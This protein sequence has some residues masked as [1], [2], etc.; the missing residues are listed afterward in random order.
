MPKFKKNPNPIMKKQAYGKA[1]SPFTMKSGN[2]TTF[3]EMGSSPVLQQADATL[4]AAA[5]AAAMASVP[6]DLSAQYK[7]AANAAIT[8]DKAKTDFI[9]DSINVV[10]DTSEKV[11]KAVKKKKKKKEK[12]E[13][14]E[15]NKKNGNGKENGGN[16]D[17]GSGS[18]DTGAG[19]GAVTTENFSTT[20]AKL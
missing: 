5:K 13:K 19:V 10:T 9:T 15:R 12:K 4:V 17:S 8:A 7:Q 16:G 20:G 2:T 14:K 1:K 6:K 11:V 18:G 3:K